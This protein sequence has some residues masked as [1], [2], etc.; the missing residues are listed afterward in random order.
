FL[1]LQ[2]RLRVRPA[3][4]IPCALTSQEGHDPPSLFELRR[5]KSQSSGGF[6]SRECEG[7]SSKRSVQLRIGEARHFQTP[8]CAARMAVAFRPVVNGR[9]LFEIGFDIDISSKFPWEVRMASN[10]KKQ[11]TK[12][13]EPGAAFERLARIGDDFQTVRRASV[14]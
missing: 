3:P 4:G 2:T 6:M 5:G 14:V 7:M 12:T 11:E 13:S 1:L 10:D 9:S 8:G